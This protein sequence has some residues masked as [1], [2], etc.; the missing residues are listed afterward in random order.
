MTTTT[1]TTMM[2]ASSERSATTA[3]GTGSV[4]KLT[5]TTKTATAGCK[6]GEDTPGEFRRWVEDG[7]AA[8]V[9]AYVENAENTIPYVPFMNLTKDERDKKGK[10]FKFGLCCE[11]DAGLA[12][13]NDFEYKPRGGG[14]V[15]MCHPCNEYFFNVA[16]QGGANRDGC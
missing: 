2:T 10:Q 16:Y 14:T 12:S 4:Q 8:V 3:A 11:C 1:T 15:M 7:D 5:T 6:W 9:A 13:E